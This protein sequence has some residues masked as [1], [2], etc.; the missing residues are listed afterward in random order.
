MKQGEAYG[1]I[2]FLGGGQNW[3][4][5]AGKLNTQSFRCAETRDRPVMQAESY[6]LPCFHASKVQRIKFMEV[7][8]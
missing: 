3:V 6:L 8:F 4:L 5:M 7:F 1:L 2:F